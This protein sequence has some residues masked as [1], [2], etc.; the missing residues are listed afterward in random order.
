MK[1]DASIDPASIV[2]RLS[3]EEL[4]SLVLECLETDDGLARRILQRFAPSKAAKTINAI[5]D[6]L[7]REHSDTSWGGID[8]PEGLGYELGQMGLKAQAAAEAGDF[9]TALMIDTIMIS[10]MAGYAFNAGDDDGEIMMQ[11]NDAFRRLDLLA[12]NAGLV[13]TTRLALREW[14]CDN[15]DSSWA[16]EGDSWDVSCLALMARASRNSEELKEAFSRCLR[17]VGKDG[18][19]E[20]SGRGK[21]SGYSEYS[22]ESAIMIAIGL[23][24]RMDDQAGRQRFI[25][26]NLRFDAVRKLAIDEAVDSGNYDRA[27]TLARDGMK[28]SRETGAFGLIGGYENRIVTILD[29]AG[30]S[31]EASRFLEE[32]CLGEH[33]IDR[34]CLL[35]KRSS[36]RKKWIETRERIL[37]T[38]E[39]RK[40]WEHVG[41]ILREEHLGERLLALTDRVPRLFDKYYSFIGKTHP[42]RVIPFLEK[43]IPGYFVDAQS[44][45]RYAASAGTFSEYAGYAGKEAACTLIRKLIAEYPNRPAMR[46]ELGKILAGMK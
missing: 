29:L 28:E 13:E 24:E 3:R 42:D 5:L 15:I 6:R 45:S 40:D 25:D 20:K 32:R 17:F 19:T 22:A 37:A 31:V 9:R 14:A 33:S 8:D 1:K 46:E 16:R 2:H 39:A 4:Q 21:S 43:R 11:V 12:G 30:K 18:G 10:R 38:F 26:E 35:K 44:R 34:F 7:E 27:L 41:D 36:D 23:Y